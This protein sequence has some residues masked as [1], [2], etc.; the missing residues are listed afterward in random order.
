MKILYL[1]T[2]SQ[3]LER[4]KRSF[5]VMPLNLCKCDMPCK[6]S[7]GNETGE[8][9]KMYTHTPEDADAIFLNIELASLADANWVIRDG[10]EYSQCF[11]V[12]IILKCSRDVYQSCKALLELLSTNNKIGYVDP[13]VN[14][15]ELEEAVIST[16]NMCVP[17]ALLEFPRNN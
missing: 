17:Y 4:L 10:I 5:E 13:D 8:T 16:V 11:F 1:G 9:W 2:S 7:K 6:D 12:P 14:D 15:C 3:E